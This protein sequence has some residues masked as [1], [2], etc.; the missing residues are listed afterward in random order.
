MLQKYNKWTV[1]RIFFDDPYPEGGG[2]G[3]RELSRKTDLAPTS[4][5]RYLTEL[6]SKGFVKQARHRAQKIPLYSANV[7]SERYIFYKKIHMLTSLVESDLLSFLTE[8]CQPGMIILFGPAAKG[9]YTRTSDIDLYV[10]CKERMLNLKPFEKKLGRSIHVLF[11]EQFD[12]LSPEL[13]NNLIN[14]VKLQ[15]YLKVF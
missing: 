4:V 14:G 11:A 5:K 1:A 15:G 13:K 3:L 2:F 9:E 10:Q 7:E 8:T 6:E 12:E